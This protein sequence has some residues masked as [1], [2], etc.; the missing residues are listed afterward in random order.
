[1]I[2]SDP[3]GGQ[4]GSVVALDRTLAAAAGEAFAAS[5]AEYPAFR[6]VFPNPLRRGRALRAFFTATVADATTAGTV[7]AVCDGPVVLGAAVWLPPGGFPWSARRKLSFDVVDDALALV[8]GGPT[9][10]AMR[11]RVSQR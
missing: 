2:G 5:H 10:T 11:R 1:M 3:A 6:A 8:P 9:H 7:H 4:T